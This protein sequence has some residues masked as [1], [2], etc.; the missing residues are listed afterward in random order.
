MSYVIYP[1]RIYLYVFDVFLSSDALVSFDVLGHIFS[2][3]QLKASFDIPK[4]IVDRGVDLFNNIAASMTIAML[5][6][7]APAFF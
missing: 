1:Q 4:C 6:Y 5:F 3:G 7:C 2:I